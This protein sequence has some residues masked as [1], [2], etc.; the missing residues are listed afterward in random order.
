MGTDMEI[1][2]SLRENFGIAIMRANTH[3]FLYMNSEALE[4]FR[5]RSFEEASTYQRKSLFA[6]CKSYHHFLSKQAASGILVNER[7][8][9][10]R[11]DKS[12][13]WGS[14]TSRLYNVNGDVRFDEIIVDISDKVINEHKLSEK[15][16]LLEKVANELDRFIYSASHDLRSPIS[17]MR[18]L[19][20]LFRT[21]SGLTPDQFLT[22]MEECMTKLETFVNRLVEFS[23]NSNEPVQIEPVYFGKLIHSILD[24]LKGHPNRN[25]MNI[26]YSLDDNLCIHSDFNKLYTVLFHIIKNAFDYA[27]TAKPRAILSIKSEVLKDTVVIEVMDNGIG[28]DKKCLPAIFQ[29]FYRGTDLSKGSG[30]GLFLTREALTRLRGTIEI[31]SELGMGT[32]VI[33]RIPNDAETVHDQLPIA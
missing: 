2:D 1:L 33:L 32:F 29:M 13:F 27:D 5:F 19:I 6:D 24:E 7:I 20:S 31:K 23:K 14:V 15:S 30:L 11:S 12:N 22:M 4:M 21:N 8:L 25:R 17:S 9:F 26:E 18:G 16:H 28:I 10:C 3:G